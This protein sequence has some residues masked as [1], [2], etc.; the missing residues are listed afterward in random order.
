M[1]AKCMYMCMCVCVVIFVYMYYVLLDSITGC[2]AK[3][4]CSA[5]DAIPSVIEPLGFCICQ[6]LG[7]LLF[8]SAKKGSVRVTL[9]TRRR[10]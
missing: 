1:K 2:A 10:G 7:F 6:L 4:L 5:V 8:F 3:G 9:A